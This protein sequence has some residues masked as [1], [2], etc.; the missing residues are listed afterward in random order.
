MQ[1]ILC[2]SLKTS[3]TP[4]G[5]GKSAAQACD[6]VP[7]C[8]TVTTTQPRQPDGARFEAAT[9]EEDGI[10]LLCSVLGKH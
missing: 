10:F 2:S 3:I 1:V 4:W 9:P 6:V 7:C 5:A 8:N